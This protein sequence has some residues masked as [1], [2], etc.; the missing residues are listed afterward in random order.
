MYN[1]EQVPRQS[2]NSPNKITTPTMTTKAPGT[3]ASSDQKRGQ[4]RGA[5]DLSGDMVGLDPTRN[6][7]Q[8]RPPTKKGRPSLKPN[9]QATGHDLETPRRPA[10]KAKKKGIKHTGMFTHNI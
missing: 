2:R 1:L 8:V 7:K 6:N 3:M 10:K 4:K 5:G 9:E